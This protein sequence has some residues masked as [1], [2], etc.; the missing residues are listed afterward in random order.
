MQAQRMIL[1]LSGWKRR[2]DGRMVLEMSDSV[3]SPMLLT[4]S[5]AAVASSNALLASCDIPN[6]NN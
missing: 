1:G 6:N 3:A 2:L 4:V 5:S